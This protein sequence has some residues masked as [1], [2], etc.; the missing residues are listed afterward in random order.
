MRKPTVL[1]F[2]NT[3]LR[4]SETFIA[5]VVHNHQRYSPLAVG[6][7]E[8]EYTD[9]LRTEFYRGSMLG[10]AKAGIEFSLGR[11]PRYLET[12]V[13]T[14]QP[15]VIHAHFGQDGYLMVP[16]ARHRRLP[17]V[18]SFY[19]KDVTQLPALWIWRYRYRSVANGT[20]IVIAAS[21]TMKRQLASLGFDSSRIRVVRFGL[22]F[23]QYEFLPAGR[24]RNKLMMIGRFVEKKGM[25]Y[26]VRAVA[27]LVER[28][29]EISMDIFGEGEGEAKLRQLVNE[30]GLEQRVTIRGFVPTDEVGELMRRYDVLVVPSVT[31]KNNDQEGLPNVII[32][33]MASGVAVV[34]SRHAAI[35][36]IVLDGDTGFL[37][38]EREPESIAAGIAQLLNDDELR[39]RIVEKARSFVHDEHDINNTVRQIETIYDEAAQML[40]DDS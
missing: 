24:S 33:G 29:P 31:A 19:G 2:R 14:H 39:R 16:T 26:G 36:E 18:V 37:S 3:F 32:E 8:R 12:I 35:P 13:D 11:S 40:G 17:L 21:N 4:R 7:R 28:F 25:E 1:H 22:D 34:A 38:D 5:R 30:L 27:L 9:G 20:T 15:K 23:R 6:I 10:L